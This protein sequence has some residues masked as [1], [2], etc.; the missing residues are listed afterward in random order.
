MRKTIFF[1]CVLTVVW[2]AL[3]LGPSF[4]HLLEAAPRINVWPPELWRE[5]TVFNQQFKYFAVAGA[6][7]DIGAILFPAVLAFLLRRDRP[8]FWYA[9]AGAVL[10]AASLATWFGVVA[11]VNAVLATWEPGPIPENFEAL[12]NRWETGHIVIACIKLAG[13]TSIA[14]SSLLVKRREANPASA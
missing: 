4:A 8:A 12:R 13:L 14:M 3:S 2:A 10:Y 1:W 6:P 11:P 9:L 7:I 5:T